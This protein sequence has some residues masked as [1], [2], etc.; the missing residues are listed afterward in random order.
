MTDLKGMKVFAT[1]GKVEETGMNPGYE[2]RNPMLEAK[3]V[4]VSLTLLL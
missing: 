1:K 3:V 2:G 4:G